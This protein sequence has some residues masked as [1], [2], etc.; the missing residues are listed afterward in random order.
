MRCTRG[1]ALLAILLGTWALVLDDIAVLSA[2]SLLLCGLV[3][4]Y[5][6][7]DRK[8]RDAVTSVAVLRALER[9]QVRKG[10]TVQVTTSVT[11]KVPP[12]MTVTVRESLLST[13][14]VQDGITSIAVSP[15]SEPAVVRMTYRVTP[16]VHGDF[17]FSGVEL[18]FQDRFFET[19]MVLSA[20]PYSGPSLAVQPTGLFEAGPQRIT[21]ETREIEKMSVLSGFGI[22][23]L[24]EYYAGD[25]MR[26]ID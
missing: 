20:Q 16:L 10:A 8:V 25:D 11:I 24:R 18:V 5:I 7:F 12:E 3:G 22:R 6:I 14:A 1:L 19:E 15:S 13:L 17:S 2:A 9:T 21:A 4:T 23:A 26:K